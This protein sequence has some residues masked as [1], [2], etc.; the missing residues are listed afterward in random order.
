[1]EKQTYKSAIYSV[2]IEADKTPDEVFDFI[3]DLA[4]WW[5]EDIDGSTLA[6][7]AEFELT[8][9]E[10]HYSRNRVID[11][12]RGKKFAWLTTQSVRKTDGFD[13]TGT[14]MIFE[15]IPHGSGTHIKYIYDGVVLEQ[16]ADR[17]IQICNKT[18][19]DFLCNYLAYGKTK[20]DF[21]ATIELGKPV[22]D[23]F[24]AL[25]HDVSKWWGGKDLSG[26]TLQLD[27]EFV[28]HHPGAHYS[29]QKIVELV[30]DKK[31]IW[32]VTD[33][34][35]SWLKQNK[36]EWTNTK[37]IFELA[38]SGNKTLLRFTHVGLTPDKECYTMCTHSGWDI[39]INDYLYNYIMQGRSHFG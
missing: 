20:Q 39:V 25:T 4:K 8:V 21:T 18:I 22:E 6:L 35:L 15:L 26:S 24:K 11:F 34:E 37:L 33:S 1:M 31:L 14:K 38:A 23:V 7:G 2:E 5:P 27:D 16:E 3:T 19:N 29:K 17:L 32:Q 30:P 12:E 13:W 9:G 10:G 36:H 28:I